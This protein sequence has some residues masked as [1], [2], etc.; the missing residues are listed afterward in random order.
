[1]I[2]HPSPNAGLTRMAT[3]AV[4]NER[5]GKPAACVQNRFPLAALIQSSCSRRASNTHIDYPARSFYRGSVAQFTHSCDLSICNFLNHPTDKPL[6][7][8]RT[9]Y[10]SPIT[11]AR[12]IN[13]HSGCGLNDCF[14]GALGRALGLAVRNKDDVFG[15]Q[16]DIRDLGGKHGPGGPGDLL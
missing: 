8:A 15:L 12:S 13:R 9:T 4:P 11:V 3:V 6:G 7:L 2:W 14:H 10:D 1:M 16:M 5:Q